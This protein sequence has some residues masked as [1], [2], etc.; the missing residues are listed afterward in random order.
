M[1]KLKNSLLLLFAAFYFTACT[2]SKI[3]P[4]AYYEQ[5]KETLHDIEQLYTKVSPK[6]KIALVFADLDFTKLSME[7]RTDTV[8][9]IYDF[10][11]RE[12]RVNDSLNKFGYDTSLVQKII[13]DMR[14]IKCTWI[15]TLDYYVDGSKKLLL[16][17]SVPVR[18]FSMIPR[19][20]KSK[21]YLFNFYRQPQYYDAEG[22][23][24]DKKK[25]SRLRKVNNEVFW[26]ITDKVC[27]TVA[28]K[29]R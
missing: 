12:A 27:Y 7:F 24:L 26:R 25:L 16:F 23:L 17:V 13:T 6:G 29:F 2:V 8:R 1:I 15:N 20:Q 10:N 21:Y 18:Q 4:V 22:R 11:Y 14:T 3:Y 5:N 28:G 9:Y 19:F